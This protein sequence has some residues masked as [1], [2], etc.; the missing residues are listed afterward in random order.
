MNLVKYLDSDK[1]LKDSIVSL[2]MT[3]NPLLDFK[4]L[5]KLTYEELEDI[6]ESERLAYNARLESNNKVLDNK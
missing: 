3:F 1:Y 4:D 2:I 5:Y 6:R